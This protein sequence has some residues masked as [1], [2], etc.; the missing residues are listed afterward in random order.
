MTTTPTKP[1]MTEISAEDYQ[2]IVKQEKKPKY[3]NVKQKRI[4]QGKEITLDSTAEANRFDELVLM[5]EQGVIRDLVL[6]P[7]FPLKVN[8]TKVCS[9]R[10]DFQYVDCETGET[11]IEDTKGFRTREFII[12]KRLMK[13]IHN[14]DVIEGKI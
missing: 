13:A 4:W 6:Q 9:Y 12:K 11:I 8:E 7:I 10:P 1:D 14:I 5:Q 3:R 2:A